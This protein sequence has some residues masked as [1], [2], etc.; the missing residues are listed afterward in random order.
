MFC[1]CGFL[2]IE[3]MYK[4]LFN[5]VCFRLAEALRGRSAKVEVTSLTSGQ[6]PAVS[7]ILASESEEVK[8]SVVWP[9]Y[10]IAAAVILC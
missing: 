7:Q 3:N 4:P 6:W 8:A 9:G 2:V 1:K 10:Y 5:I